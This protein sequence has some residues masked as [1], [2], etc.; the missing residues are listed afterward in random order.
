[1][2]INSYKII[3]SKL[4]SK[5]KENTSLDGIKHKTKIKYKSP[6][7]IKKFKKSKLKKSV[8]EL[9]HL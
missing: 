2:L 3:N 7:G 4:K 5:V 6:F 8:T 1:M 9:I